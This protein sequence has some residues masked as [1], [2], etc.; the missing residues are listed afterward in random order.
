M[1]KRNLFLRLTRKE[2]SLLSQR[3]QHMLPRIETGRCE[4]KQ[5]EESLCILYKRE[6]ENENHFLTCCPLYNEERSTLYSSG[7]KS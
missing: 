3:R 7:K 1:K 2:R 6:V 4:G 5:E